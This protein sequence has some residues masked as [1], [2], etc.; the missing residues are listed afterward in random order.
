MQLIALLML[1]DT[2]GK[3]HYLTCKALPALLCSCR[4]EAQGK[5]I[6]FIKVYITHYILGLYKSTQVLEWPVITPNVA[7]QKYLNGPWGSCC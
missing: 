4:G 3:H 5:I 7:V 1:L 2:Q 6:L